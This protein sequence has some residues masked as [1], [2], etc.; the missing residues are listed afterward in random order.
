MPENNNNPELTQCLKVEKLL[1]VTGSDIDKAREHVRE[2]HEN[3]H[4]LLAT[5]SFGKMVKP[6]PKKTSAVTI[7]E[8]YKQ[9]IQALLTFDAFQSSMFV[10]LI[11]FSIT[12]EAL[13]RAKEK[14]EVIAYLEACNQLKEYRLS[15]VFDHFCQYLSHIRKQQERYFELIVQSKLYIADHYKEPVKKLGDSKN[16][17]DRAKKNRA[18]QRKIYAEI[19]Q[20]RIP[21]QSFPIKLLMLSNEKDFNVFNLE[22]ARLF[23]CQ[24]NEVFSF[25]VLNTVVLA[26]YHQDEVFQQAK[27][28]ALA[29]SDGLFERM[30]V[31][32]K[33]A[34]DSFKN[35][36]QMI[37]LYLLTSLY[38][39]Y[40]QKSIQKY[41]GI[42]KDFIFH[43]GSLRVPLEELWFHLMCLKISIDSCDA[44]IRSYH[45]E[46]ALQFDKLINNYSNHKKVDYS[47]VINQAKSLKNDFIYIKNRSQ[48]LHN[49]INQ[50]WYTIF[51][52]WN[53]LVDFYATVKALNLG[54][55]IESV[56]MD[57]SKNRLIEMQLH[58]GWLERDTACDERYKADYRVRL[59]EYRQ[60][61]RSKLVHVKLLIQ[62]CNESL[63]AENV[64]AIVTFRHYLIEVVKKFNALISGKEN[65]EMLFVDQKNEDPLS[66]L[67]VEG[68]TKTHEDQKTP[69]NPV[70]QT[71]YQSQK[72][73][74]HN[75]DLN[76][77][78]VSQKKWVD[79][80]ATVEDYQRLNQSLLVPTGKHYFKRMLSKVI[81]STVSS[82][83]SLDQIYYLS[84]Q[85]YYRGLLDNSVLRGFI[86]NTT[87]KSNHNV[88][89]R[90]FFRRVYGTES[91][92][93]Q[94]NQA[95]YQVS[96]SKDSYRALLQRVG[97]GLSKEQ[98]E[99][100]WLHH[101]QLLIAR[102]DMVQR[103][104]LIKNQALERHRAVPC[105]SEPGFLRSV[106][107]LFQ[108]L[109]C[110]KGFM[111]QQYQRVP[112]H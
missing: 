12:K 109:F 51:V 99:L 40:Y 87:L 103:N 9:L 61:A 108:Y 97:I 14:K 111:A 19:S 22:S 89:L 91:K 93:H 62:R 63:H 73:L 79:I 88:V 43:K 52:S 74:I 18:L 41:T 2:L 100:V 65:D 86:Q 6:T 26:R 13:H 82:D 11:Q 50:W 107:Q 35:Q 10:V 53:V 104:S 31:F 28:N 25:D 39:D 30:I 59:E 58:Q 112:S 42:K 84:K 94:I 23:S 16:T 29:L 32:S 57:L 70:T 60:Q 78:I 37:F 33:K 49:Q 67:S 5:A 46:F 95:L 75:K 48:Q 21:I 47:P 85:N 90:F 66:G 56:K 15:M 68:H 17:F 1:T 3:R 36:Q 83:Q 55:F 34:S 24:T 44:D 80:Q 27:N 101:Q 98:H 72:T 8:A 81:C 106:G 54:F 77:W 64:E 76:H 69:R 45:D 20:Y 7:V 71:L 105:R 102:Q 92:I 110:Y 38:Q 96:T 4:V